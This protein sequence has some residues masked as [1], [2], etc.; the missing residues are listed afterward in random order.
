MTTGDAAPK[1]LCRAGRG[2][3]V[4]ADGRKLYSRD[5]LAERT[6]LAETLADPASP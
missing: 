4:I 6:A 1:G 3:G 2:R 5:R